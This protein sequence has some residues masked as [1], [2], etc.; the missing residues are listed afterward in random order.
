ML[1]I[2]ILLTAVA[3]LSQVP[4]TTKSAPTAPPV[5]QSA[6]TAAPDEPAKPERVDTDSEK[7]IKKAAD[8][9][10]KI[11]Y[12]SAN[13]RQT[14]LLGDQEIVGT[15]VYQKGPGYR[16]RF[17]LDVNLGAA[18][19]KRLSISDGTIGYRYEKLLDKENVQK[20][21]MD[22]IMRLIDSKDIDPKRSRQ[23]LNR[24]PFVRPAQMLRGYLDALTFD[25]MTTGE[26]GGRK[27][28][29]VEGHWVQEALAILSNNPSATDLESLSGSQPQYVRLFL[30]EQ[31][32]WPLKTEMFRRDRAALY[33]PIYVLEFLDFRFGDE[34][35]AEQ[36]FT[37]ELPPELVPEDLT[38]QLIALLSNLPDKADAP[39]T[40]PLAPKAS[41][42]T[43]ISPPSKSTKTKSDAPKKAKADGKS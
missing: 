6:S 14:I 41:S 38:A 34:Q 19:G 30:D 22:R 39:A 8:E 29:V 1:H 24:F 3:S 36:D 35:L 16:T 21:E 15:G 20:F 27:V 28:T 17:E 10:E 23:L 4:Q 13:L 32:G 40:T 37:F 42:T 33:K 31:T 26:L 18:S 2:R 43:K 7:A 9:I 25:K 12:V 11:Q 5:A